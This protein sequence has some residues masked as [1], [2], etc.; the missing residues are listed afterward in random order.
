MLTQAQAQLNVIAT[1]QLRGSQEAAA[2]QGRAA[3][4]VMLLEGTI[5]VVFRSSKVRQQQGSKAGPWSCR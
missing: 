3:V 2:G 5:K 1:C 4:M